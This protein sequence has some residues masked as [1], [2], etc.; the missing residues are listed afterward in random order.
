MPVGFAPQE[1]ALLVATE[2]SDVALQMNA[3]YASA[4]RTTDKREPGW[5]PQLMREGSGRLTQPMSR[6]HRQLG[7][8][9]HMLDAGALMHSFALLD[10]CHTQF[11]M[12]PL[13]QCCI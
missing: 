8:S 5:V 9:S 11:K 1:S 3:E 12:S 7:A 4:E 13:L 2:P 6:W 10:H